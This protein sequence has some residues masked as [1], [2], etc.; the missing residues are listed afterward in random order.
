MNKPTLKHRIIV[1]S[2][3]LAVTLFV[4]WAFNDPQGWFFWSFQ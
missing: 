4:A 1:H 2:I 3:M